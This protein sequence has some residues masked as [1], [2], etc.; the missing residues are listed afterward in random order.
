MEETNNDKQNLS[1]EETLDLQAEY[2]KFTNR[3]ISFQNFVTEFKDTINSYESQSRSLK[4]EVNE[5][6]AKLKSE[7]L[8][9]NE[10]A[11]KIISE[12][13]D[14]EMQLEKFKL[15]HEVLFGGKSG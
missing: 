9:S 2:K 14:R 8:V 7:S 13:M 5:Q 3:C 10:K 4:D 11:Y 6:K 1:K 12:S 15:Q